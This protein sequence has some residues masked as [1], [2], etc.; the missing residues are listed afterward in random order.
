M[1]SDFNHHS[2]HSV[3]RIS[4]LIRYIFNNVNKVINT[5]VGNGKANIDGKLILAA[6]Q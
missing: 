2:V 5:K 1:I 6:R 3:A 4:S